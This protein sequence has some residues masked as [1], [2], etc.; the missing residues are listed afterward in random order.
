MCLIILDNDEC[1]NESDQ[2]HESATCFNTIGSFKCVCSSGFYA[3][4]GG[5]CSGSLF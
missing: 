5:I 2:C 4:G 1:E 3:F